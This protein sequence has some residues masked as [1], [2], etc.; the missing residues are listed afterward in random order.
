MD[1]ETMR[2]NLRAQLDAGNVW[3]AKDIWFRLQRL[4]RTSYQSLDVRLL[5]CDIQE[6]IDDTM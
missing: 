3:I 6:A 4:V 2:S 1:Y 5:W